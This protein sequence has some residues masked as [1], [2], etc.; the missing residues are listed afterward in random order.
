MTWK[1]FGACGLPLLVACAGAKINPAATQEANA[2]AMQEAA[3]D[4]AEA[5]ASELEAMEVVPAPGI[6]PV[7]Q[8]F[9]SV[10]MAAATSVGDSS[11][12][13]ILEGGTWKADPKAS[14]VKAHFY[15]AEAVDVAK[16]SLGYCGEDKPKHIA[17][18]F[19]FDE[20]YAGL[21]WNAETERFEG[22]MTMP[23][24]ARSL[25][26]NFGGV[27]G[28]CVKD[29]ELSFGP[30]S[31]VVFATPERVS[32]TVSAT[33]T[34]SP[35]EAYEAMNL[36]DS[37]M[38]YAWS[39]DD[40]AEGVSLQFDFEEPQSFSGLWI[41]NGYQRS[42]MHCWKN[43]RPQ[44]IRFGNEASGFVELDLQDSLGLQQL[45]FDRK[46]PLEGTS[47]TLTILD[48]YPGK[49]YQDTVI[50]ELRFIDSETARVVGL[51]P[52]GHTRAKAQRNIRQFEQA[53]LAHLVDASFSG[54]I[55]QPAVEQAEGT[56]FY[57]GGVTLRL[58]S[59]GSFYYRGTGFSADYNTEVETNSESFG[60]GNYAIEEVE[61]GDS[62]KLRLFGLLR[63][64]TEE[65]EMG[66]DC[67]G[68]GRD[69][70]QTVDDSGAE[71]RL[72]SDMVNVINVGEGMI[73]I[74]NL[75]QTP[76]L[77]FRRA[78]IQPEKE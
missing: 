64:F 67:N 73:R 47:F 60:L 12:F 68:C 23:V 39:S 40:S 36:F 6:A 44:R 63:D 24:S 28:V 70:S 74:D 66:M 26:L 51:D 57:G 25:T 38:E 29:L 15:F 16:I 41:W 55:E 32:G 54:D 21:R 53:G 56:E 62:I 37:R 13:E 78:L 58:R 72:F 59:D 30:Q 34:L 33:S 19:N 65:M 48:A 5:L 31:S 4:V 11:P 77:S 52:M 45:S 14:W 3:D 20:R 46:A 9:L 17:A 49:N 76:Q 42:A 18:Y 61:E 8:V 50:S 1:T 22:L 10:P 7:N 69:C 2:V 71:A 27:T 43:A 35:T 75:D